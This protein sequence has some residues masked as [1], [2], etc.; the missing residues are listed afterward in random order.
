MSASGRQRALTVVACF[1]ILYFVSLLAGSFGALLLSSEFALTLGA[2]G[3]V[4]GLAGAGV[5]VMRSRGL[6]PMQSGLPVFIGINLLFSV[7]FAGISI[8]GHIGGLIA[9]AL[10]AEIMMRARKLEMPALGYVGAVLVGIA[11]VAIA[12]AAAAAAH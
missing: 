2:S 3:A 1:A 9:G 11:S 6:D 10:T 7:T 5:M 12:F 4:F 8:G